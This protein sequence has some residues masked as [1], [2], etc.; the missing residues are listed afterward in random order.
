[1]KLVKGQID[2]IETYRGY[3]IVFEHS[4][5]IFEG[6]TNLYT[7]CRMGRCCQGT[8]QDVKDFI[9]YMFEKYS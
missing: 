6:T 5:N 4:L 2:E 7:I 9:D 1:M 8:I 3:K